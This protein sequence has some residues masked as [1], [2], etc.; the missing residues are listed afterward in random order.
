[1]VVCI[2]VCEPVQREYR[3][4]AYCCGSFDRLVSTC[5]GRP[6]GVTDEV[7]TTDFPS[8]L[9][10]KYITPQG[11]RPPSSDAPS[12]KAVSYHYFRLRLLQSEML[13]VLQHQ[14]AQRAHSINHVDQNPFMHTSL[15]SPFLE[16]FKSFRQW[17][18]D[19]DRRLWE[20]KNAAPGQV[21]MKPGSLSNLSS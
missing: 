18:S 15:A 9:D 6:F 16:R 17:R 5:V 21:R 14:Q 2:Q 19:I 1:M 11:F 12:Y 13:Q 20:W 3:H 4:D 8:I 7:I 10:D